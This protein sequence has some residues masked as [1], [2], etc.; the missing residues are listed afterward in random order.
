MIFDYILIGINLNSLMIAYYL[1]KLDNKILI[2]DKKS[3]E[4][5]N[6]YYKNNT[7]LKLPEYSNND[8]NF[9]NFLIDINI[10]FRLI[11]NKLDNIKFNLVKNFKITELITICIEFI[12][13][14]TNDNT[15]KNIKFID[16]SNLFSDKTIEYIKILCN[17]YN[18]IYDDITLSDFTNMINNCLI[19]EFFIIDEKKLFEEIIK[20]YDND[21]I[22]IN[23]EEEFIKINKKTIE[24]NKRTIEFNKKCLLFISPKNINFINDKITLFNIYNYIWNTKINIQK[25][26][27]ESIKYNYIKN[28]NN[29]QNINKYIIYSKNELTNEINNELFFLGKNYKKIINVI[30]E[31]SNIIENNDYIIINNMLTIEKNIINNYKILNNLQYK[32]KFKIYKNDSIIDIIKLII[33]IN[34]LN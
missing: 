3:K 27:F 31:F 7:V 15:S 12:K 11:G 30:C 26:H 5:H 21:Y 1:Y 25:Y 4:N 34:Y 8:V 24:T 13:E 29:V 14:F 23:Y 6:I 18:L 10:D 33:L 17:F 9:L 20:K 19:N 32:K 2:I 22:K 28:T 16:K